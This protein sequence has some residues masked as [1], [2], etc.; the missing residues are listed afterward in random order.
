MSLSVDIRH[1]FPGFR[2][3]ARFDAPPGLTAL[4]GR[5]GSGKTTVIDAVAGLLR[6]E[7][8][9]IAAGGAVL[10][11]AA[12]GAF[13]P[14]HRRRVGYVFQ[15]SRLFPHLSVRQNLGFGRWFAPRGATGPA[16][17]HVVGLLGIGHLLDRRPARL[18]G[19][20]RQRVAIGRALL[21]APR[22]LLLDE[23]L[24]A[25]DEAR[26]AEI[27]PYLEALRD[28]TR[29]PILYVSHSVAE[30]TR[31]ATTVVA[32]ADGAVRRVGP[33][34]DLMADPNAFPLMGRQ[35]AGALLDARVVRHAPDG[36]TELAVSGGT[37]WAPNVELPVGAS[38]RV[39]IRARDV[40]LAD[41]RPEGIS[42]LNVLSCV[43]EAVSEGGAIVDVGLR[44]GADRLLARITR[45]SLD[46]L[47]L[48][49]GGDCYAIAK[50][51]GV[52]RRDL[53]PAAPDR[54]PG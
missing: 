48:A 38:L 31:L 39:R 24:A 13:L 21:A 43:V 52:G 29:I 51:I 15:D 14:P 19:G 8:G 16:F 18:S 5:S 32:M 37:L 4:F 22:V 35:E 20:E 45:R 27:M 28:E 42:A 50:S 6:P 11:D 12:A 41:R 46:A 47:G 34:A 30:V 44:C 53:A 33:P 26:K 25:L 23:P 9:R 54:M 7:A 17:D 36:L 10:F 1:A 2:L 49:P 40:M 3:E